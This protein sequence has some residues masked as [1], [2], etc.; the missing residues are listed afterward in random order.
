M[1]KNIIEYKDELAMP[2]KRMGKTWRIYT[3]EMLNN[4]FEASK[5]QIISKTAKTAIGFK[6]MNVEYNGSGHSEPGQI[7]LYFSMPG[8]ETANVDTVQYFVSQLS[9]VEITSTAFDVLDEFLEQWNHFMK[10]ELNNQMAQPMS[11]NK[12]RIKVLIK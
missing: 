6:G 10:K 9:W 4:A 1:R 3:D 5:E 12:K 11:E 7:L 2:K 8:R